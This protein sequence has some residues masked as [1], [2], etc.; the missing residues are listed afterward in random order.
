MLQALGHDQLSRYHMN[1]GHAALLT[2]QLLRDEA[3]KAGRTN[4]LHE[5]FEAVHSK[6]IFTTHTPVPA[7]H[8]QFPLELVDRVLGETREYYVDF[9]DA[10]SVDM[11][12]RILQSDAG[13]AEQV[14][15]MA[16]PGVNLN[17]TYL[18]LNLSRYVNGVAKK[19]GEVSRDMFCGYEIDAITNG[20][21]A[22]SWASEEMQVLFDRYMPD[23]RRDSFSLR[24]ALNIPVGALREAHRNS[25]TRLLEHI[26]ERTGVD[27]DPEVFTI[28]FARR[29][30]TYKRADLLFHDLERLEKIAHDA[31]GLQIVYAGKA[32]P[33]DEPGQALIRRILEA[34]EALA[35]EIPV[36][37]LA[38]YD[39]GLARRMT[40]GVDIWLNTPMPPNE[41]SGTSGMKAALNGTPT[42][43][44]LDGWWI[45]GCIEGLTGWAIGEPGEDPQAVQDPAIHA[46]SLY[47]KLEDIILPLFC[48]D[49]TGFTNVMRHSI[50]LN[51]AFF[52]TQRMVQQYVLKAY[53]T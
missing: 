37:Y 1:E 14:R 19:H 18:A 15:D 52:N 35:G 28:G 53:F 10:M 40:A 23:W 13:R 33:K 41:A 48:H 9:K 51:G 50:A 47:H 34:G 6:C 16:R 36:V 29:A 38:N 8:D 2:F 46:Q 11:V 45:E 43:S 3:C 49:P 31:G 5:D 17:M 7:G 21:H 42:L 4:I 39:L 30:A 25:K 20:V 32:H 24:G 44:V 12:E 22:A 27:M 26:R